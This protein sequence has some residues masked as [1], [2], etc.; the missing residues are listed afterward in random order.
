M[1]DGMP[2]DSCVRHFRRHNL[3][4]RC[5]FWIPRCML[6]TSRSMI[7]GHTLVVHRRIFSTGYTSPIAIRDL[8]VPH[9]PL[10][11]FRS[12]S[13]AGLV[14]RIPRI[15]LLACRPTRCTAHRRRAPGIIFAIFKKMRKNAPEFHGI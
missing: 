2:T 14:S 10:H 9:V 13:S 12:G 8:S 11:M 1:S 6:Q 4:I 7:L 5:I 3:R 15:D